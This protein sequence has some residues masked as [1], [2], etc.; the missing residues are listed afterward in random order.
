MQLTEDQKQKMRPAKGFTPRSPQP[1]TTQEHPP[2]AQLQLPNHSKVLLQHALAST[3]T[4]IEQVDRIWEQAEAIVL[5]RFDDG[6]EAFKGRV[7]TEILGRMGLTL[8]SPESADF[9]DDQPLDIEAAFQGLIA[10]TAIAPAIEV[11]V[12]P[13]VPA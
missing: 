3:K 8:E 10:P 5:K 4:Q 2:A 1:E 11:P 9:F 12:L 7:A 13:G 6:E